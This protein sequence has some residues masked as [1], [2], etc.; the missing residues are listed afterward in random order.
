MKKTKQKIY[1]E[2]WSSSFMQVDG[3]FIAANSLFWTGAFGIKNR[4][5]GIHVA[6]ITA[7]I[8]ITD[9]RQALSTT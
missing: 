5:A 2:I 8:A 9:G 6:E 7:A 1:V 4:W 3:I